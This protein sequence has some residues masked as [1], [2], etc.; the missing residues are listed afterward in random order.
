MFF[1]IEKL[2]TLEFLMY[3]LPTAT[4]TYLL[5]HFGYEVSM[6]HI[7]ICRIYVAFQ[8]AGPLIPDHP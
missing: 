2:Y 6:L 5:D 3:Y 1:R 8:D 4:Y 7:L